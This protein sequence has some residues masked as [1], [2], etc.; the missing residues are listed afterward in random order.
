MCACVTESL[1][2]TAETDSAGSSSTSIKKLLKQR[3]LVSAWHWEALSTA[4]CSCS[5]VSEAADPGL[6]LP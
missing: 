1:C 4:A 6:L 3:A 5:H 2:C